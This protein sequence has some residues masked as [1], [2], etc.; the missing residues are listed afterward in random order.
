MNEKPFKLFSNDSDEKKGRFK[1]FNWNIKFWAVIVVLIVVL[2][3]VGA[4]AS[5]DKSHDTAIVVS[6]VNTEGSGIFGNDPGMITI[7]GDGH[8]VFHADKF[9]GKI[10]ATP[11]E[12][13]IQHMM[14]R[15]IFT[16]IGL[17]VV[18]G[19][20]EVKDK[21]TVYLKVDGGVATMQESFKKGDCDG[22]IT[23]EP[24][25]SKIITECINPK[26]NDLC[27]TGQ[28]EGYEEHAC[29]MIVGSMNFLKNNADTTARFLAGYM[30]A[31]EFVNK[32]KQDTTSA[33]FK[34]VLDI[35]T[36]FL[37]KDMFTESEMI[38]AI[39]NV[40]Y[41]YDLTGFDKEYNTLLKGMMENGSIPKNAMDLLGKTTEQYSA[42][43]TSFEYLE[44]AKT[45]EPGKYDTKTIKVAYLAADI[46][47]LALHVAV[48]K[49]FF[50]E[51][52]INVE[53]VGPYT[54]GGNVMM[55]LLSHNCDIAFAG[56]P[57]IA[58]KTVNF[59][60]S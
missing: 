52:G 48:Q 45:M 28:I 10:I 2:A 36:K 53:L 5:T 46:H 54:N 58:M 13:S 41:C 25:Y 44:K 37:G 19:I 34:E 23:W 29:C 16:A 30:K 21:N 14:I 27:R 43:H 22:G 20:P 1:L 17:K 9:G 49:G 3:T 50:E 24:Y 60:C 4:F 47:Q 55:A 32:A 8:A 38:S 40:R 18:V 7:D 11:G 26:A 31:V 33:E 51:Y 39:S 6:R 12:A 35:T 56:A 59:D 42:E 57:P 15:D